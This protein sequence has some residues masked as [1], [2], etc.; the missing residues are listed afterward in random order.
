MDLPNPGIEPG[1]PALQAYSLPSELSGKPKNTYKLHLLGK[2]LGKGVIKFI[3][4]WESNTHPNSR[5]AHFS[6]FLFF[7]GTQGKVMKR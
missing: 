5:S 2:D 3:Y 1:S 4:L 7:M 6:Q